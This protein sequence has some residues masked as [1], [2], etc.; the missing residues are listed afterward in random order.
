MP[1]VLLAVHESKPAAAKLA[2]LTRSWWS[3]RGREVHEIA[4]RGY[5]PATAAG[6][7]WGP[8]PELVVSLGGDGTMLRAVQ[9]AHVWG[10]PV[11]GV[12]LGQMGY[13]TEVDP[14]G[15][16]TAFERFVGGDYAILERMMLQVA[17]PQGPT[18]PAL[19]EVVIE[20]IE[21]G[22][23][24]RFDLWISGNRFLTYAADGLIVATATG[25][26]AYNLSARGPIVS[27][28]LRA[29]LVTPISPHMLLDR[30]LVLEPSDTIS[31]ELAPGPPAA[32]VVDGIRRGMLEPG[33]KVSCSADE[34]PA[35]LVSFGR[36][37]F[38]G[39]LRDKFGLADR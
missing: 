10:A 35:R 30:A 1:R 4:E 8:A 22:H 36:S 29:M 28:R 13:L 23:T 24:I 6:I 7:D 21:V 26:T 32:V 2:D 27:P 5:V 33:D 39:V 16:E 17:L 38:L 34:V 14:E 19:N 37:D 20:K 9:R 3:K 12:N 25:S 11:L 15:L 31:I 18:V